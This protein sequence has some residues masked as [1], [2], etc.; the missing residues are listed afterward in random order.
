MDPSVADALRN[1]ADQI[2]ADFGAA[3]RVSL[4]QVNPLHYVARV[5]FGEDDDF[6]GYQ[7]HL[8]EV[9]DPEE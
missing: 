4:A 7:V 3:E 9:P 5:E 6:D 8:D 2:P 1:L